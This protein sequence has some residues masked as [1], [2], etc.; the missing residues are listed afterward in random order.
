MKTE[1]PDDVLP[2]PY[3]ELPVERGPHGRGV[4]R[5]VVEEKHRY[6]ARYLDATREAQKKFKQR[7]LIDPFSGPG[8]IQVEG[9]SLHGTADRLLPTA[10]LCDPVHRSPN[11]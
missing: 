2:D 5:W 10:S 6:L 11:S 3:P 8:R 7:V 4:G 1:K 9:E